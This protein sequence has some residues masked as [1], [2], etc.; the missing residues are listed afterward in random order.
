[1]RDDRSDI[2]RRMVNIGLA[3]G[4]AYDPEEA[5]HTQGMPRWRISQR[6]VE[7]ECGCSAERC[8]ELHAM[9]QPWDPIIF[10]GLPQQAVYSEVCDRHRP[11]MNKFVGLGAP[12]LTFEQW[13][14][15]RRATLMG[16]V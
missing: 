6:W 11:G 14:R 4:V 1:M 16:R 7:F 5:E 3:G 12:G 8:L 15:A 9:A 10:R 2:A 13:K